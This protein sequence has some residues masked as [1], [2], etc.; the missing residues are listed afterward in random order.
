MRTAHS[1]YFEGGAPAAA[2]GLAEGLRLLRDADAL[3]VEVAPLDVGLASVLGL[4]IRAPEQDTLDAFREL[5][6]DRFAAKRLRYSGVS[7]NAS[8]VPRER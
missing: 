7:W 8:K 5:L 3:E 6:E 2:R 1:Y 4:W